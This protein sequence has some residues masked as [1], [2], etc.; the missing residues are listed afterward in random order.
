MRVLIFF[1]LP[2]LTAA[3]RK[4]YRIF[5]HQLINEGFLM[6]Q[7]SVYSRIAVNRESATFLENRVEGFTPKEGLVQSLIVTE[8]QY[9]SMHFLAGE[10]NHDVRNSVEGTIII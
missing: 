8:K 4:R 10:R 3:D 9:N 1:D 2:T 7:E 6:L 5:R